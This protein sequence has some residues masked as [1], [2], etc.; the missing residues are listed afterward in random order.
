MAIASKDVY[1]DSVP[2][3][4][5]AEL[6]YSR[7]EQQVEDQTTQ[8]EKATLVKEVNDIYNDPKLT[9]SEKEFM[10]AEKYRGMA[11]N[12]FSVALDQAVGDSRDLLLLNKEDI[13]AEMLYDPGTETTKARN[14]IGLVQDF[15]TERQ[16]YGNL[17]A[18]IN[19]FFKVRAYEVFSSWT[20]D[21]GFQKSMDDAI[22]EVSKVETDI[23]QVEDAKGIQTGSI[24]VTDKIIKEDPYNEGKKS[25]NKRIY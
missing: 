20:K 2:L 1:S 24:V 4:D 11:E 25:L 7:S 16:K 8:E 13:I 12:R 18:Y 15:E 14:V 9:D 23:E 17:A 19:T 22:D 3:E 5:A 10:I 21:K 6:T